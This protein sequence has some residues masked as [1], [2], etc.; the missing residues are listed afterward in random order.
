LATRLRSIFVVPFFYCLLSILSPIAASAQTAAVT[1]RLVDP[2]GAVVANVH[3]TLTATGQAPRGVPR[4]PGDA[5][6]ESAGEYADVRAAAHVQRLV[7]LRME[8]RLRSPWLKD[9]F[10]RANR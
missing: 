5:D 2:Q 8:E 1:G 9:S 7:R 10:R 4:L 6:D 3:I